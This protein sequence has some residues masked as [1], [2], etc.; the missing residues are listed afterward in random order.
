LPDPGDLG[1]RARLDGRVSDLGAERIG[2]APKLF[3]TENP[4]WRCRPTIGK[5]LPN[6]D[7]TDQACVVRPTHSLASARHN[8]TRTGPPWKNIPQGHN[9][10]VR[11]VLAPHE[12]GAL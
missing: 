10:Y 8:G 12:R 9:R 3:P 5:A 6:C 2:E 1:T 11:I 4:Q 7:M